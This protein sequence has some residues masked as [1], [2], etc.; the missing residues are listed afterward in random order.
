[1]AFSQIKLDSDGDFGIGTTSP[2]S[3]LHVQD[4]QPTFRLQCASDDKSFIRFTNASN[5]LQGAFLQYDDGQEMFY[6]GIHEDNNNDLSDDK[7]IL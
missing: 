6:I 5:Y 1:V 7:R 4:V 3:L 2:I